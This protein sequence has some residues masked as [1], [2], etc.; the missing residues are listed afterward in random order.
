MFAQS[1]AVHFCPAFFCAS[2]LLCVLCPLQFCTC[3]FALRFFPR[4]FLLCLFCP[5]ILHLHFCP[6]FLLCIFS[7]AIFAPAFLLCI[8]FC[9]CIF[10]LQF[11]APAFFF[12]AFFLPPHFCS[13]FSLAPAFLPLRFGQ[14]DEKSERNCCPAILSMFFVIFHPPKCKAKMQRKNEGAATKNAPRRKIVFF[15]FAV[16]AAPFCFGLL[17]L[18]RWVVLWRC[19]ISS[20]FEAFRFGALPVSVALPPPHSLPCWIFFS[21]S[22][23]PLPAGSTAFSLVLEVVALAFATF[24]FSTAAGAFF[25]ATS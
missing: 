10:A 4:A 1:F 16:A 19:R 24:A 17:G 14:G 2:F 12:F 22:S 3:I 8:F 18:L 23:M 11:F 15:T 13:A 20:S 5:C 21:F 7:P 25:V 9:P 6:A